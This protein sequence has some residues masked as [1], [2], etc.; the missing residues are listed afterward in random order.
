MLTNMG[1]MASLGAVFPYILDEFQD[2]RASTAA[3]QSTF[4]GVGHCSGI[5]ISDGLFRLGCLV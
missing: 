5:V 3:I 2:N 4:F 1:Y